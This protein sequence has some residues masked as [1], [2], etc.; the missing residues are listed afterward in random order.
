[1]ADSSSSQLSPVVQQQLGLFVRLMR[2]LPPDQRMRV[3]SFW[4]SVRDAL[5][6]QDAIIEELRN[7]LSKQPISSTPPPRPSSSLSLNLIRDVVEQVIVGE[8][9]EAG[10]ASST[11][12]GICDLPPEW[13][14]DFLQ[15][16]RSPT[17]RN[18]LGC[19]LSGSVAGHTTGYVKINLRNTLKP[20]GAPGEK[21]TVQPW[22][23]QLAVVAGG[24]GP[25]LRLTS[26]GA[27]NVGELPGLFSCRPS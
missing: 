17:V 12:E 24:S 22:I 18:E 3:H 27:Y 25:L 4:R 11:V 9:Q 21:F 1:M 13:A 19:W 8:A 7:Q 6:G 2:E 5:K 15:R 16:H 26:N 20:G 23:H 10:D 14:L